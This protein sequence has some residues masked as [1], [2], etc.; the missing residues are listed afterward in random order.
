MNEWLY[1]E[2]GYYKTFKDIGKE[3][4]FYTAVST[5]SFFGAS[6][7]NHFYKLIQE[8][9]FK[10]D[11]WL[12]EVGAH[13]G[14][15]LCDMIQW[16][17]TLDPTLVQTL[18][19]GIVERQEHVQQEQLKYI[20]ERFGSDIEISHFSDIDEVEV[21]YAFV[22]ANEIFDAFPCELIKDGEQAFVTENVV[23]WKEAETE[24][25]AFASTHRQVKGEVAV[26]YEEFALH[27][28]KGIKKCDFVSFDY[29][30]KFVRNDFSIRV[31]EQHKTFPLFDEELKL[32][33]AFKKADITYDVNFG[34]VIE[35]FEEA[36]FE[37]DKYE[38]QAR[39]L[40]RF[41]LID[42]LEKF[43]KQATQSNYV[44]EADK[45]KTLIAPTIMGDKFKMVHFKK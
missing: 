2:E 16:L 32:E 23:E 45:I 4:D 14:Y 3:G 7:A 31:Y 26:G 36:G 41:G 10:R 6:I 13:K 30:E 17:Y 22:V 24:L 33:E 8:E 40:V 11:G 37:L 12:I 34:H 43:A 18:K 19:F 21:D 29:G 44:R 9:S 35:A 27:M 25:L 1:G 28:G 15:L 39:A 20:E 42:I 38:T 5:S